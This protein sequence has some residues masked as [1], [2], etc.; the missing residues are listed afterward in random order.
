MPKQHVLDLVAEDLAAWIDDTADQ[1]V[2]AMTEGGVTPFAAQT[3]TA[4]RLAYYRAQ[5]FNPDG[6]PNAAGRDAEEQRLGTE[7]FLKALRTVVDAGLAPG[8]GATSTVRMPAGPLAP[9][10]LPT[11]S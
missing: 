1:L 2:E 7:G 10:G 4:D 3:T 8:A 6:S 11:R 5:F 9:D